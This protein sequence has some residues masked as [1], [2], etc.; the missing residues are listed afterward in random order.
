MRFIILCIISL[1]LDFLIL[2]DPY[3]LLLKSFGWWLIILIL[4]VLYSFISIVAHLKKQANGHSVFFKILENCCAS[5]FII[6]ILAL[7]GSVFIPYLRGIMIGVLDLS[8]HLND[9]KDIEISFWRY[10]LLFV[11]QIIVMLMFGVLSGENKEN[12][13]KDAEMK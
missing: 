3:I 4:L 2:G 11:V 6:Y 1:I 8:D 9:F 7:I 10:I 12:D 13:N 5:I